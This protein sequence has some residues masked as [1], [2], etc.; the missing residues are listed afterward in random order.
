MIIVFISN[1]IT[2]HQIP[3]CDELSSIPDVS[4]FFIESLDVDKC[5]LPVGWR[6]TTTP[7]Y[8]IPYDWYVSNHF[9]CLELIQNADAV[10]FGSGDFELLKERLSLNKLTFIYSERIYKNWREYLK[11]PYHKIKFTRQYSWCDKLYLL[12]ASA[13]SARDYNILGLFRNKAFKW[14]YFTRIEDNVE[15]TFEKGIVNILWCGRMVSWKHPEL[16]IE[17]ARRLKEDGYC[18]HLNMIGDGDQYKR[19]KHLIHKY[20]IGDVVT[21]L[22]VLSNEAVYDYMKSHSIFLFTSDQ[23]EGWGAVANESMSNGCV[24]VASDKIGSVPYLLND[25]ENGMIF[26]NRSVDSIYEKVTFLLDNET[27][28]TEMSNKG[29]DTVCK[30]WSPKNAA[31]SLCVLIRDLLNDVTPSIYEGPC[32]KA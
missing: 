23:N 6:A 13:F 20:N 8:V 1:A 22:G 24:L 29:L 19:I 3:L 7:K 28:I 30:L 16:A 27:K 14:G 26:K 31:L 18:F 17:L 32:S 25:G 9:K 21:L 11:Y 15:R 10:V 5:N 4:F 2:P 12:S